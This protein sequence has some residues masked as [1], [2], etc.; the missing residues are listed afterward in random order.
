MPLLQQDVIPHIRN[1]WC[2]RA[3]KITFVS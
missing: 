1:K 3:H 2:K